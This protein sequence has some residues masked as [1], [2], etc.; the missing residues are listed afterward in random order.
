LITNGILDLLAKY[1]RA[2]GEFT[3]FQ[4]QSNTDIHHKKHGV[5]LMVTAVSLTI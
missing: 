1:C 4:R 5:L 3:F 2:E